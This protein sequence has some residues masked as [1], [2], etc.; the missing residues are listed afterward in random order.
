MTHCTNCGKPYKRGE[1]EWYNKHLHEC[2]ECLF[3][4]NNGTRSIKDY[5]NW[6]RSSVDAKH[7]KRKLIK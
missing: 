4:A 3:H 1:H 7:S 2:T 5:N 6:L